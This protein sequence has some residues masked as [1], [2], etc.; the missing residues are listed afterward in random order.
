MNEKHILSV[1][2]SSPMHPLH[3]HTMSP[4]PAKPASKGFD[5]SDQE[6]F[7]FDDDQDEVL[8]QKSR[9]LLRLLS[10]AAPNPSQ[11]QPQQQQQ[12]LHHS[13][14]IPQHHPSSPFNAGPAPY[15]NTSI[16][17]TSMP[18][19][20][21]VPISMA[22]PQYRS[23]A[24][25]PIVNAAPIMA[26]HHHHQPHHP[27][28]PFHMQSASP[29]SGA[30]HPFAPMGVRPADHSAVPPLAPVIVSGPG[31]H[32]PAMPV[33]YGNTNALGEM[34]QNLKNMLKINQ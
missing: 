31:S 27:F 1:T 12:Q 30:V 6:V 13:K 22:P 14:Q 4:S 9:D 25:V 11:Q 24:V 28:Q 2:A 34:S 21:T 17:T 29:F 32:V 26:Q 19:N 20:H 5:S 23:Q 3:L 33:V 7:A 15:S 18:P 8:R 16:P 10:A